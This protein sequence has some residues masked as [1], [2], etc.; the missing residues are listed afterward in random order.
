MLPIDH[1]TAELELITFPRSA[2]WVRLWQESARSSVDAADSRAAV[3]GT[4]G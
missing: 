1:S 2:A 3:V 4:L